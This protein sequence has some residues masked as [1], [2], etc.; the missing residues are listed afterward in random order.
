[1]KRLTAK[2]TVLDIIE[3]MKKEDIE[4]FSGLFRAITLLRSEL[5]IF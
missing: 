4:K 5:S 3:R 2:D 1:M